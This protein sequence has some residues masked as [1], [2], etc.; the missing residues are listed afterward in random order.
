M[1][2]LEIDYEWCVEESDEFGDIDE[3]LFSSTLK[4]AIDTRNRSD[5]HTTE[6][7]LVRNEGNE[8]R[9]LVNKY[10]AYMIGDTLPEF[11]YSYESMTETTIRVP[12][13]FHNEVKRDWQCG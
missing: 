1:A 3:V 5:A 6:I 2:R 12:Q 10:Y 4:E 9:G 11:F 7:V 8:E 13:K